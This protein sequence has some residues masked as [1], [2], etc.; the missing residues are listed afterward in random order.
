VRG[1]I[2]QQGVALLQQQPQVGHKPV[3]CRQQHTAAHS[4]TQQHTAAHSSTQ[5]YTAVPNGAM[6][7]RHTEAQ[8]AE[9]ARQHDIE[10]TA[11]SSPHPLHSLAGADEVV[12]GAAREVDVGQLQ[13]PEAGVQRG[14]HAGPGGL[15]QHLADAVEQLGP[16]AAADGERGSGVRGGG[17]RRLACVVV[18]VCLSLAVVLGTALG[19]GELQGLSCDCVLQPHT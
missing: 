15:W 12:K 8:D 1:M 2:K 14:R 13:G 10:T 9:D 17:G 4:S 5:Q 16:G 7:Q 11:R 19:A 18:E 3:T 6:Q